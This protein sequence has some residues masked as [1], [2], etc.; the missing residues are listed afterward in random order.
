MAITTE[1]KRAIATVYAACVTHLCHQDRLAW[2][3][4]PIM[5]LAQSLM[6]P[7]AYA[8]RHT[9]LIYVLIVA[10]LVFMF[11]ALGLYNK[12]CAD[13]DVN[14]K[15]M[16]A[17]TNEMLV[18]ELK[19]ADWKNPYGSYISYDYGKWIWHPFGSNLRAREIMQ[20]GYFF[21]IALDLLLLIAAFFAPTLLGP[22]PAISTA[23]G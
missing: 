2:S 17:M 10:L 18:E 21:L 19:K 11:V 5:V 3:F 1:D 22:P 23:Q 4:V 14:L 12:L 9:A 15:I 20:I 13:R 7:A 16:D 6:L 8:L